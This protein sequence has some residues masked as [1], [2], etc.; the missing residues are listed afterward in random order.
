V[1]GA[2]PTP[3]VAAIMRADSPLACIRWAKAAFDLSSAFGR[4]MDCQRARR[5]SRG[6]AALPDSSKSVSAKLASTPATDRLIDT[7]AWC[8]FASTMMAS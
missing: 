1:R 7:R 6:S 4:P 2:R 5:A 3:S 8:N